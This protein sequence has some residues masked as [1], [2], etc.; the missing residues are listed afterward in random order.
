MEF[1]QREPP[2]TIF[3]ER[4]FLHSE[5]RAEN[6]GLALLVTEIITVITTKSHRVLIEI[7]TKHPSSTNQATPEPLSSGL[8]RFTS[9]CIL[10]CARTSLRPHFLVVRF[11][12]MTGFWPMRV[13]RYGHMT[14]FWPMESEQESSV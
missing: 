12:Y 3:K 13:V 11:G 9:S 10:T 5:A 1:Y 7:R 4:T 2:V 6:A 14:G 8:W